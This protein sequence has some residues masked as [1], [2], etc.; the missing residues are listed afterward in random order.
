MLA[1]ERW[2]SEQRAELLEQAVRLKNEIG[3]L[4]QFLILLSEVEG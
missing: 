2:R 4:A 3:T 1:Y